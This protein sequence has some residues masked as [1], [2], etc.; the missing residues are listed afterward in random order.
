MLAIVKS[1]SVLGIDGI[2]VHVEADVANGLPGTSIVGLGDTA[3]QE[4]KERVRAAIRNS[5][6]E[7][8]ATRITVNLAPADLRKAGPAFDLAIALAVLASEGKVPALLALPPPTGAGSPGETDPLHTASPPAMAPAPAFDSIVFLAEVALDGRLRPVHGVLAVAAE[9]QAL[10]LKLAV[11][12]AN[13]AEA[14][15]VD[16]LTVWGLSS[17]ND[18]I[19]LVGDPS[20][21]P[22][23]GAPPSPNWTFGADLAEVKGQ[24]HVRRGLEIAAAGGH[25]LAMVGPPG[26]GK[27]MLARRLPSILPPMSPAEALE[28]TKIYSIAGSLAPGA[29]LI[30]QRPFRA[31]HHSISPAGLVGGG[32]GS[33]LP[34]EV[35]MA[36]HGVLFLDELAEFSRTVLEVLRQP[37]EDG[38]V[39]LSRSRA[40]HTFPSVFTLA[41]A[42]NPC[43]CGFAG[44]RL[45]A[46]TCG[47]QQVNRYWTRISGPLLDRIDLQI[48]VPRLTP[49]EILSRPQGESSQTVRERVLAARERQRH[50]FQAQPRIF[51][52]SQIRATDLQEFCQVDAAGRHLLA[53]ALGKMGLSARSYDRVLKV[54]RTIA[55]LEGRDRIGADQVAEAIQYRRRAGA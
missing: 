21:L 49:T 29:P 24:S 8:P 51:A 20:R 48:G 46:C 7:Y 41:A 16:G 12:E 15:L 26:S 6:H 31:P 5:G 47:I 9:I 35:S 1:G 27:T 55:D 37:L 14:A 33:P 53:D 52:N 10:G 54:A 32:S 40:R 50:R 13:A 18:A 30:A 4:S 22:F 43:P 2:L 3:V 28:V 19:A 36:T 42:M 45:H 34:G 17:L 11:C 44:D 25:N 39:T 23:A 38:F